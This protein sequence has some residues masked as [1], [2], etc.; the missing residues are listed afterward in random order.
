MY[1]YMRCYLDFLLTPTN[2]KLYIHFDDINVLTLCSYI[3]PILGCIS[4]Y[5][6]R[7][8]IRYF[9]N[10]GLL[11]K[12]LYT[13]FF[14]VYAIRLKQKSSTAVLCRL[15]SQ[16]FPDKQSP[17]DKSMSDVYVAFNVILIQRHSILTAFLVKR[18]NVVFPGFF[19]SGSF[20]MSNITLDIQLPIMSFKFISADFSFSFNHAAR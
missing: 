11:V 9:R 20:K 19:D 16:S 15:L 12:R 3:V 1:V 8:F 13:E 18:F 10:K 6:I 5:F 14:R 7:Y 17:P 2:C 4:L